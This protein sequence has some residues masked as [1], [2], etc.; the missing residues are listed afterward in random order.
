M[1]TDV[2][3]RSISH[4]FDTPTG[5]LTSGTLMRPDCMAALLAM[6]RHRCAFA[7]DF[8]PSIFYDARA[9]SRGTKA[10][11]PTSVACRMTVSHLV[12]LG[13][14]LEKSVRALERIFLRASVMRRQLGPVEIDDLALEIILDPSTT[15]MCSPS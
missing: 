5:S 12:A 4:A 9:H 10:S 2:A 6:D 7:A 3:P 13:K 14:P 11:T 8:L 15:A 1:T